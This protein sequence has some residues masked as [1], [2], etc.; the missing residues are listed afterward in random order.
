MTRTPLR[1]ALV[2]AALAAGLSAC[3]A[4]SSGPRTSPASPDSPAASPAATGAIY[5]TGA[6]A[7]DDPCARVVSAIGYLGLS[8]LPP[9]Q[10]E[11]Q[12]WDGDVRG[13]FGYLRG[14]LEMYGPRLPAPAKDAVAAV[15]GVARTL[16]RAGTAASRRPGLLRRYRAAS[17]AVLAACGRS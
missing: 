7:G 9:G 1:A 17:A 6:K 4:P 5:V 12:H 3:Q 16:S 15:D 2:V 11:A 13:R 10:E 8:L 14:T